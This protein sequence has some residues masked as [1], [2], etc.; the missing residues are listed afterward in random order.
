MDT[1]GLTVIVWIVAIV[2]SALLRWCERT[3]ERVVEHLRICGR[4]RSGVDAAYACAPT[5][6]DRVLEGIRR[7]V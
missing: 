3:E 4:E 5:D 6:E 2:G 1:N 7:S